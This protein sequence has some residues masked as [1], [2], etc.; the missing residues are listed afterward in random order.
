MTTEPKVEGPA[1]YFPSIERKYEKPMSYWFALVDEQ[2]G[3]KHMEMVNWL[4]SE[5]GMG[6]EFPLSLK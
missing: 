6:V 2:R 3:L 5:H 4:K 1:F